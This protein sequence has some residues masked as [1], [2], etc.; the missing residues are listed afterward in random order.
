MM[1]LGSFAILVF[2][3]PEKPSRRSGVSRRGAFKEMGIV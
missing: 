2:S 1:L 3:V